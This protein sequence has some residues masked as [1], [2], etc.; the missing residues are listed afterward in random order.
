MR[1]TFRI[2]VLKRRYTP[3]KGDL[4][5]LIGNKLS[6]CLI[7]IGSFFFF[8]FSAGFSLV[9]FSGDCFLGQCVHFQPS[10]LC[11]PRFTAWNNIGQDVLWV[12]FFLLC[13]LSQRVSQASLNRQACMPIINQSVSDCTMIVHCLRQATNATSS[14]YLFNSN[15]GL[16][17]D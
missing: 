16:Q 15:I 11:P 6:V 7:P 14:L 13:C 4:D 1:C 2:Y 17:Q 12:F 8:S 3:F 10:S 5:F 9:F